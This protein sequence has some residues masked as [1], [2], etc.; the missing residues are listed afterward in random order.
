MLKPPD[1]FQ[2]AWRKQKGGGPILINLIHEIDSLRY[3]CGEITR[4]Y[5][6]VSN[7]VREFSVE[8]SVSV[9]LRFEGGAL[10]SILISDCVSSMWSYEANTGENP[11]FFHSSENCYHFFGTEASLEF[12]R[13]RR[14]F[15]PDKA[16]SG[17]QYPV[18]TEE[19][20]IRPADP[21]REQ[22]SHFCRGIR[23]EEK[24][25]TSGEDAKK[26]LE[27]VLAVLESGET[28]KPVSLNPA[29]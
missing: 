8:D 28:G 24:P 14:V 15:Y 29:T 16:K 23:G 10:G 11:Y 27:V 7:N 5:A 6:E 13:L 4:V 18:L 3:V 12:P 19:I 9:S 20:Q 17:W 22:L 25:R 2:V 21:Y 26:T 1:C